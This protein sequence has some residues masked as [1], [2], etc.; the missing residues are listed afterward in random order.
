MHD[1]L[2]RE[3]VVS[4]L[5][6]E[7]EAVLSEEVAEALVNQVL[8][9]ELKTLLAER[10]ALESVTRRVQGE[11]INFTL[12]EVLVQAEELLS[13]SNG[14]LDELVSSIVAQEA[15]YELQLERDA[16]FILN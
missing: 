5:V 9:T 15:G 10:V 12:E 8:S 13:V 16:E 2:L 3:E 4:T 7:E 14:I 11:L 6:Q 1:D